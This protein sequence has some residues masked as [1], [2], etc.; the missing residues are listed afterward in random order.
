MKQFAMPLAAL[1]MLG[2]CGGSPAE[3][4]LKPGNW[5]MSAGV[6]DMNVPGA[7]P[8]QVEAFKGSMG[9]MAEQEQC[10][11]AQE[12]KFDPETMSDAFK[13]GGDCTTG[14]FTVAAGTI[15]G[16]ISCKMPDGNTTDIAIT[17]TIAPEEFAMQ[18]KTEMAQAALPE[19]KAE[20]TIEVKGERIGDC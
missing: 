14:D 16:S 19:G 2:A 10:V 4:E 15:E 11:T 20:L 18:A 17:G 8:E 12:A 7:S 3:D 5:K 9:Q 1:V 6:V 13:Q